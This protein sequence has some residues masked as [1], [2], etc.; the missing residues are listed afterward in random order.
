MKE[1]LETKPSKKRKSQEHFFLKNKL[2]IPN[3]EQ[4]KYLPPKK[5]NNRNSLSVIDTN[6]HKEYKRRV[7]S[8]E[9]NPDEPAHAET[10]K[11]NQNY[12]SQ[13][14]KS[15]NHCLSDRN[16]NILRDPQKLLKYRKFS[17]NA[18]LHQEE[19]SSSVALK[20]KLSVIELQKEPTNPPEPKPECYNLMVWII[21]I[22]KYFSK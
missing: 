3:T 9:I 17:S 18:E 16:I 14:N 4:L 7:N 19:L 1:R 5:N 10:T 12:A 8:L 6:N 13:N 21:L 15:S 11:N 2:I 20:H 22:R